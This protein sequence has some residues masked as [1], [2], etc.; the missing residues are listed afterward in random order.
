[1]YST[2]NRQNRRLHAKSG[3]LPVLL[4]VA[5]ISGCQ[6]TRTDSLA[7][8]ARPDVKPTV[9][10]GALGSVSAPIPSLAPLT[11]VGDEQLVAKVETVADTIPAD[12]D[13]S[14]VTPIRL[15]AVTRAAD[16][17]TAEPLTTDGLSA[18]TPSSAATPSSGNSTATGT[19]DTGSSVNDTPSADPSDSGLQPTPDPVSAWSGDANDSPLTGGDVTFDDVVWSVARFY[20][21]VRAAYLER[22]IADGQQLAAWGEFDTKLK[23]VSEN[24]PLGFYETYRNSAGV[25]QPLYDGGYVFGGYRNGGGSFEPWY[26]ERE[27]NAG[28]EFKG[29]FRVPLV[30]NHDIDARRAELWRRTFDQQLADPVI[31]AS[32]IQF[33]AEA[34]RAYWKW[35]AAGQKYQLGVRWLQLAEQRNAQIERRVE[36]QDLDPPQLID[37]NRA[38]AKR[39]AKV[40]GSLRDLEQAAQKLSVFLRDESGMPFVPGTDSLPPFPALLNS[41]A[42]T[43]ESDIMRAQQNRPELQALALE[44]RKLRVDYAEACNLTLPQLDAQLTGSQ[45]VGEPTSSK[46]DKSEFE[47]EAGLYFE[48]PVQQRKGRGK[49]HAVQAKMAQ[50][51]AK[52]RLTTDKISA[53]VQAARIGLNRSRE[54]AVQAGEAADLA[55]RMRDIERTKFELGESDLLTLFLREQIALD[56][57][58]EEVEAE[59]IHFSAFSDYAAS[60]GIDRPATSLLTSE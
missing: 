46:R 17:Q 38:I 44:L 33:A 49:M 42:V 19:T 7:A 31:R 3:L 43:V 28:G 23:A 30:R 24:Q 13:S 59:L 16:S 20:P 57:A 14:E 18:E 25:V 4:M 54:A 47:V 22:S 35:V 60:L 48:M 12:L 29:G 27:T 6:T 36:L 39:Q 26:L 45:D 21:M 9:P 37:N 55:E 58:E 53:E 40:A 5:V 8:S 51:N 41:D 50:V 34:G 15:A 2:A 52:Q 56:A 10:V 11:D 32:L 1:M